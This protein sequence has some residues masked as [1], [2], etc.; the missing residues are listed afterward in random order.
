[1]FM[2]KIQLLFLKLIKWNLV[3]LHS[4]RAAN[5]FMLCETK[6]QWESIIDIYYGQ[7]LFVI[8]HNG[9]LNSD[10]TTLSLNIFAL[11]GL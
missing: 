6:M 10:T 11:H 5:I 9:P 8:W 1:M 2:N 7:Y 4:G 3:C